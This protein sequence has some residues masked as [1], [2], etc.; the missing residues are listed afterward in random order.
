MSK[1][2]AIIVSGYFNPIH[3]GHLEYINN[4]KAIA[5]ELFVIVNSDLQRELKGS[6]AFQS[7]EERLLIVE[8]LKAVDKA[9]LS[10]DNDRTVCK[11]IEKIHREFSKEYELG[12][13]NGG[14]QNNDTIPER[15]ICENLGIKLIDGLGDKIQSSSWLLQNKED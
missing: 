10:I 14:D 11:T 6:K 8:N 13:A 2:R 5:D 1:K 15:P 3:K 4:A 7:E 9:F 12:F